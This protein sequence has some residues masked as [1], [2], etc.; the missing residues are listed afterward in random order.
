V[1][2]KA[3]AR[4]TLRTYAALWLLRVGVWAFSSGASWD[5]SAQL[6]WVVIVTR[7]VFFMCVA[8]LITVA[9]WNLTGCLRESR[10]TF[11]RIIEE[12]L[13]PEGRQPGGV[14]I[15]TGPRLRYIVPAATLSGTGTLSAGPDLH[16]HPVAGHNDLGHYMDLGDEICNGPDCARLRK[17]PR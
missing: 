13:A 1:R 11:D 2:G 7:T 12:E 5:L 14:H 15:A 10:E 9:L 4:V 8:N 17:G 3:L 16:F 6:P